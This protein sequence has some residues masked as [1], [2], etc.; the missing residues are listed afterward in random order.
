[1][2]LDTAKHLSCNVRRVD[3]SVDGTILG[4]AFMLGAVYFF[5]DVGPLAGRTK[6]RSIALC[7][8]SDQWSN[9]VCSSS[10]IL[11]GYIGTMT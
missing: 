9:H 4:L 1:M 3:D 5:E 6:P 11:R 2:D 8:Q 10:Q 7:L